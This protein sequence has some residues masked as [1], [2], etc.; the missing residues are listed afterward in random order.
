MIGPSLLR[1]GE[2]YRGQH[3]YHMVIARMRSH[4]RGGGRISKQ[5]DFPF[6]RYNECVR[7]G[8]VPF[9]PVVIAPNS[10]RGRGG[11]TGGDIM[12]II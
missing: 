10:H 1:R 9:G 5:T 2:F 8:G 11:S 6:P 12:S 3:Y 7:G 4:A